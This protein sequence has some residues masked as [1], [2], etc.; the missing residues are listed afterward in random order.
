MVAQASERSVGGTKADGSIVHFFCWGRF[1]KRLI[2]SAVSFA[3]LAC[4]SESAQKDS[5]DTT[6]R[7]TA[8][9]AGAKL[10]LTGA[11]ATFPFPI[12]DKW[13]HEYAAKTGARSN[14]QQLGSGTGV[15]QLSERTV[16]FGEGAASKMSATTDYRVSIVNASGPTA[17]PIASFTWLLVYKH[18]P[19]AAKA[20]TLT[21]F[22]RWALTEGQQDAASLDYAP[23]PASMAS[24]L[25]A[26]LDSIRVGGAK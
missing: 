10:D 13:F 7:G 2:L 11:G 24:K 9:S 21:D 4:G 5:G 15:R 26:R 22:I 1:V 6:A 23:L 3:V 20:K 18:Q 14:Y 16:D 19:D 8:R 25:T 12:Y 17:Y